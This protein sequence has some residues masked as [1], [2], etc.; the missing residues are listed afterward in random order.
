MKVNRRDFLNSL[1][2]TALPFIPNLFHKEKKFYSNNPP[3][4][5]RK[6]VALLG[7]TDPIIVSYQ[8]AVSAMKNLPASDKRSWISQANIHKNSCQH[9]L[10]FFLPWHRCYLYYF[11]QICRELSGNANFALPYWN[12]TSAPKIPSTLWGGLNPLYDSTRVATPT[13]T[14]SSQQIGATTMDKILN[15]KSFETFASG[16]SAGT[17]GQLEGSPHNY[18]HN[19]FVQGNMAKLGSAALDPIFW[20]HHANIDRLWSVWNARGNSNPSD[21]AWLGKKFT[22][23]FFDKNGNPVSSIGVS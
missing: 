2:L 11:E 19:G 23:M 6:D 20:L 9:H 16:S 3:A 22:N 1:S 13:S 15:I 7:K 17:T 18:I 21:S 8:K 12:W 4:F 14:A 10:W 5:T